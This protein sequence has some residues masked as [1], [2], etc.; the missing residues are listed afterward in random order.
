MIYVVADNE[1]KST[2]TLEF[3]V[4]NTATDLAAG[5][6]AINTTGAEGT[7]SA[8]AGLDEEGYIIGS[9]AGYRNANNQITA[10]LWWIVSGTVTVAENGII[11]VDA[12]NS[13][14]KAIKC[15]LGK[16]NTAVD[17]INADAAAVKRIDNGQL[18]I[19]KNGTDY[20]VMGVVIR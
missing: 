16:D 8:G 5:T 11:T 19:R 13:Y 4:A 7:V 9:F 10:P 3:S 20:N 6:Y 1:D 15:K 14:D 2:I 12:V 18:I 17:N